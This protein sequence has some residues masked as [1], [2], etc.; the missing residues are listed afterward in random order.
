MLAWLK[1]NLLSNGW[2]HNLKSQYCFKSKFVIKK[3][4]KQ[5]LTIHL[6]LKSIQLNSKHLCILTPAFV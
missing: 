3:R 6:L 4:D 2:V 5:Y 1:G